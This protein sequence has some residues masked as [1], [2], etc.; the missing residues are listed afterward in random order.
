MSDNGSDVATSYYVHVQQTHAK[1]GLRV[2]ADMLA[3]MDHTKLSSYD[4]ADG[5]KNAP[6]KV[7]R[8]TLRLRRWWNHF[9]Y[10]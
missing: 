6:H 5:K 3:F 8:S 1:W 9:E 2:Q 7:P 10:Q 4:C